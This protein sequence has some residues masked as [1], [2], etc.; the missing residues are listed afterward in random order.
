MY[1]NFSSLD[2]DQ[3]II[4]PFAQNQYRYSEVNIIGI[5]DI[6]ITLC[7]KRLCYIIELTLC[8]CEFPNNWQRDFDAI[9]IRTDLIATI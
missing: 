2:T 6:P 5:A 1:D 9:P 8:N 3:I 7:K 4:F